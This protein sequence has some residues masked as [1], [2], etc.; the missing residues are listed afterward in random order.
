[1]PRPARIVQHRARKPERDAIKQRAAELRQKA[2]DLQKRFEEQFWCEELAYYAY[3][4][5]SKKRLVQSVVSNPGHLLWSGIPRPDRAER[6]VRRLMEPDMWSGWGIRTLSADHA[7][8]N[9]FLYQ[10]GA[11]WPHDNGI[12]ALGSSVMGSATKRLAWRRQSPRRP[13]ILSAFGCPSCMPGQNAG[14]IPFRFSISVQIFL[15]P[16]RRGA[17]SIFCERC[18]AYRSMRRTAAS[19]SIPNCRT[20]SRM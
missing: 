7:S 17:S 11:V 2:A 19:M 12:I 3:A 6:V 13:V 4:L 14:R 9:P 16:G 20:G 10:L 18:W 5:D 8:Y 15:R 1:M